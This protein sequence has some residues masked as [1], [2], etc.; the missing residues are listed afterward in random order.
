MSKTAIV[1]CKDYNG[2]AAHFMMEVT[3]SRYCTPNY[4]HVAHVNKVISGVAVTDNGQ[5]TV[6][7]DWSATKI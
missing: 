7:E 3:D 1:Y 4:V 6:Y 5:F 2:H